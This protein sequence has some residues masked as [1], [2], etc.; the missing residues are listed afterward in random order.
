MSLGVYF[1][2]MFQ[3]LIGQACIAPQGSIDLILLN[4]AHGNRGYGSP[5]KQL[6]L[7]TC[8]HSSSIVLTSTDTKSQT[9]F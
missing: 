5:G 2:S 6:Q 4:V 8:K 1:K 7:G 3:T 9:K